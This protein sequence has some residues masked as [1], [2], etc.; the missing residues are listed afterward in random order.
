MQIPLNIHAIAT[1]S[2]IKDTNRNGRLD[3]AELIAQLKTDEQLQGERTANEAVHGVLEM[4]GVR[5]LKRKMEEYY[6]EHKRD[7]DAHPELLNTLL[8]Q[9]NQMFVEATLDTVANARKNPG[10][11]RAKMEALLTSENIPAADAAVLRTDFSHFMRFAN[12][13]EKEFPNGIAIENSELTEILAHFKGPFQTP[14][15]TP[16]KPAAGTPSR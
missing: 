16:V 4:V 1:E 10:D 12:A 13:F 9:A 6:H 7:F 3:G 5:D 8:T 15:P 11:L 14:A 2:P